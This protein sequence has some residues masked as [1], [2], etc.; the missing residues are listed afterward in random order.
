MPTAP[1]APPEGYPH[2]AVVPTRW[3]DNDVYG[4]VNNAVHYM[5]MDTVINAWLVEHAGLDLAEGTS[6]GL[7]VESGCRYLAPVSYPDA[8][9]VGLR[10]ARLGTSSVTWECLL[11]RRSDRVEVAHGRFV[12]VFVDRATRTSVPL[13]DRMRASLTAL[14]VG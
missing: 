9:L 6:I 5:A 1:P 11:L 4:H 2:V 8:L 3:N 14:V 12:H 13:E 7:C 10:V